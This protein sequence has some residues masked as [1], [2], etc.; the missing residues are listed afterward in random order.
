MRVDLSEKDISK[1]SL[2]GGRFSIVDCPGE[3]IFLYIRN[4]RVDFSV[5]DFEKLSE[6]LNDTEIPWE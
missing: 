3:G 4:I 1:K 5:K 2:S 6:E